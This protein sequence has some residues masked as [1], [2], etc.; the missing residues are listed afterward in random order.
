M[1]RQGQVRCRRILP[2]LLPAAELLLRDVLDM[3]HKH[4]WEWLSCM[5]ARRAV[6][7]ARCTA[8]LGLTC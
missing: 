8:V 4:W 3:R 5:T 1:H 2:A 7:Q 6:D